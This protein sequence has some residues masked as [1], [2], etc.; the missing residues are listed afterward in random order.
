MLGKYRLVACVA[1]G[2]L[3]AVWRARVDGL[4]GFHRDFAVRQL[5]PAVAGHPPHVHAVERECRAAAHLAH[6]NIV[7]TLDLGHTPEGIP[8]LVTEWVNGWSLAEVS[9]R[10]AEQGQAFPVPMIAWLA[11]KLGQGLAWAHSRPL[12]DDPAASFVH[13]EVSPHNILV[14]RLGEVKLS[15]F[16][17]ALAARQIRNAAPGVFGSEAR[18]TPPEATNGGFTQAGD[19]WSLCQT[20]TGL[21]AGA[22]P[23]A[24]LPSPSDLRPDLPKA[25]AEALAL[26]RHEDPDQRPDLDTLER[27]ALEALEQ[28]NV[29]TQENLGAWLRDLFGEVLPISDSPPPRDEDDDQAQDSGDG[30]VLGEAS[31]D[32]VERTA[33]RPVRSEPLADE[34]PPRRSS[35][36]GTEP[37]VSPTGD[38]DLDLSPPPPPPD[39]SSSGGPGWGVAL[40]LW[41]T[42]LLLG[43][44]AG[45]Q[46]VPPPAPMPPPGARVEVATTGERARVLVN[47]ERVVDGRDLPPGSHD[48]EVSFDG[49]P[50]WNDTVMLSD[51][52]RRLLV[53]HPVRAP[54]PDPDPGP[55]TDTDATDP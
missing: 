39:S 4:A 54:T 55:T 44:A 29:Y 17:L 32:G 12:P 11:L 18:L 49:G 9:Q 8:Y 42:A 38:D 52:E 13:G 50:T 51:G 34:P 22:P 15:N 41:L 21:L 25:L 24:S 10:A 2:P 45:Y 23:A 48:I 26:G 7:Q 31:D 30:L 1:Q 53:V 46:L 20:L 33:P 5:Q 47:G 36:Q 35:G 43:G 19:V 37:S 6:S 28:G 3:T 40:S 27:A 16:G 14:G